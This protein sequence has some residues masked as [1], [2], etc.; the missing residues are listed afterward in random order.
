MGI[1]W[2][3]N[4]APS[5]PSHPIQTKTI[6]TI[7]LISSPPPPMIWNIPLAYSFFLSILSHVFDLHHLFQTKTISTIESPF[8]PKESIFLWNI[9]SQ[10]K[11]PLILAIYFKSSHL[12]HPYSTHA[13][14]FENQRRL[15]LIL[16]IQFKPSHLNPPSHSSPQAME[17]TL[18]Y[19]FSLFYAMWGITLLPLPN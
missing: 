4:E 19:S 11:A 6:S 10:S 2:I 5:N 13:K 15:P 7:H 1:I 3:S 9:P 18:A 8:P 14:W 17:Y 12:N 16:A